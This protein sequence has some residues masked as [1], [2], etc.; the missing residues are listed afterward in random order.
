MGSSLDPERNHTP[1]NREHRDK[2]W[3]GEDVCR[4]RMC[5]ENASIEKFINDD[6]ISRLSGPWSRGYD[7]ALTWRRSPVQI[8]P[9]PPS[10]LFDY[11][12]GSSSLHSLSISSVRKVFDNCRI[13]KYIYVHKC[14]FDVHFCGILNTLDPHYIILC[15]YPNNHS[16]YRFVRTLCTIDDIRIQFELRNYKCL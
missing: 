6:A 11:S 5:S 2:T 16:K 3:V 15:F 4:P 14:A 9:G 12:S 1:Y 13:L 8:R 7:V 10:F